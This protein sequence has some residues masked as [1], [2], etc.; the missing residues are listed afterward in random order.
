MLSISGA[1]FRLSWFISNSYSKSEIARS[2]LTMALAPCSRAKSTSRLSKGFTC[3]CGYSVS[4]SSMN[5][6]RSSA[7]KIVFCLRTGWLTTPTTTLSNTFAARPMMSRWP[8]VIGSYDPGH[9]AV[10]PLRSGA[11]DRD[12]RV[13]VVALDQ[14]RERQ[15]ERVALVRFGHDSGVFCGER[16]QALRERPGQPGRRIIWSVAQ[17]QVERALRAGQEAQDVL[18]R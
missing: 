10:P 7:S 12:A 3:T 8:I 5:E 16:R 15:L 6:T 2:P 4:C 17:H 11:M 1:I 13:A 18:L 14:E 9:T